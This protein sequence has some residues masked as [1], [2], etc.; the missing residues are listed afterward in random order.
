MKTSSYKTS[1]I[2]LN[3]LCILLCAVIFAPLLWIILNSLK[4]NLELF[5]NS[6]SLPQV[7]RFDNYVKA[8][9]LG[10]YRY[11]GNSVLVSTVSL[12]AILIL[13]SFLAYGLTRFKAKGAGIIFMI[14]LGGWR[15]R[16]RWRWYRCTR[17]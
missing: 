14:V 17:Y 9:N 10:L 11:F 2:L 15:F 8:W 3:L 7:W 16:N 1:K 13:S 4:T 5:R 6:L 12:C